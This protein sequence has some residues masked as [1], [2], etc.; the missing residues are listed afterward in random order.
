MEL[1]KVGRPLKIETPEQMEKILNEYFET[2]EENKI[3]LTGMCL[4]LN[5]DKKNFY[6]YEKRE[7]Y[8]DIVKRARMIVENS[9]EISLREN[10]R[11]GDI[12]ALKNFG[13]TDKQEIDTNTQGKVT[14][15][16]SL[17]K[18]DEDESND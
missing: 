2:T 9:Y 4:A 1:R 11:T 7:G 8:E 6:E 5:I 12:F 18:D 10:G 13:W 17:P 15:I 3:T 16:N 14:I